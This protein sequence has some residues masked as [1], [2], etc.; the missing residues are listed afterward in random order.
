MSLHWNNCAIKYKEIIQ[1]AVFIKGQ[2]E[3]GL[4]PN[5]SLESHSRPPNVPDE[6]RVPIKAKP[7]PGT[8]C[9]LGIVLNTVVHRFL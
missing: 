1:S 6:D 4:R 7:L 8:Y 9:E 2:A 3:W 5:H